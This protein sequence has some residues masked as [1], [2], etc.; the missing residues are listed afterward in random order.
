[1]TRTSFHQYLDRV[2]DNP[3]K[4]QLR[5]VVSM[6]TLREEGLRERI[7]GELGHLDLVIFDE[8]HHAR[9]PA[10]QNASLLKDLCEVADCVLLLTATPIQLNS[11]DLFTLLQA[12]TN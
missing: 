4:G 8:A 3:R 12:F 7:T 5:A 10:T 2:I 6:N 1:M 9:N 11:R